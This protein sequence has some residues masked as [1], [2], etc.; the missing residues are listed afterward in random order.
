[1]GLMLQVLD[2][3][4]RDPPPPLVFEI[5][6]AGIVGVRRAGATILA[7][8]ERALADPGDGEL[9]TDG[10]DGLVDSLKGLLRELAPLSGPHA[11]LLLPDRETRLA[12]FEFEKIPRRTQELRNAVKARFH[13]SLPF[14]AKTARIAYQVQDRLRPPSVLAAAASVPMLLRWE[15]AFELVG[16]VLG[17]VGLASALALQLVSG[18]ATT[19]ILKLDGRSMTMIV[20]EDGAVLL[21]RRIAQPS[22][23]PE[24]MTEAIGEILAD[25]YPTLV[26][27]E[28]NLGRPATRLLLCGLGNLLEPALEFLPR[29]LGLPVEPLVG[30][31]SGDRLRDAGLQGYIHGR[32]LSHPVGTVGRCKLS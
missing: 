20:V 18:A 4:L 7:R 17:Y 16:L 22:G 9:R 2:R 29:E 14:D 11:A 8:A 24:D 1:M 27:V 13:N 21:V 3:L 23:L 15:A 31:E 30:G 32:Q 19:F 25:L 26:Y 10:R 5:G 12:V 6:D 28:E